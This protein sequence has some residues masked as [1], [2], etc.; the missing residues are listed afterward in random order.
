[1]YSWKLKCR[2]GVG[3]NFQSYQCDFK[4][5][6]EILIYL[7]LVPKIVQNQST[8]LEVLW[9]CCLLPN[10]VIKYN[11]LI[12]TIRGIRHF[13]VIHEFYFENRLWNFEVSSKHLKKPTDRDFTSLEKLRTH[14]YNSQFQYNNLKVFQYTLI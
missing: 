2:T 5:E 8:Y 4:L 9:F 13:C 10:R 14:L 6:T 1:M 3:M 7:S 11:C 12:Q